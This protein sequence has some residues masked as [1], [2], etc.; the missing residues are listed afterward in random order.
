MTK[1]KAVKMEKQ[2]IILNLW[3]VYDET[4]GFVYSLRAKPYVHLG[5]DE[6]KLVFLRQRAILDYQ[7][8][9]V[10]SIPEKFSTSLHSPD[11]TLKLPVIP[12]SYFKICGNSLVVF[13]QLL[14]QIEN[15]LPAQTK[16]NIPAEPLVCITPLRA[17]DV[18]DLFPESDHPINLENLSF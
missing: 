10:G 1:Q 6:E 9:Y 18:G 4:D 8:A 15:N 5:S 12:A 14:K 3:W 11:S 16:L 17:N 2:E 13:E 7:V